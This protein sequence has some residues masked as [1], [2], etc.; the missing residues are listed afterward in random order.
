MPTR[1]TV[2]VL[3]ADVAGSTA[4]G[5]ALDPES[6]QR[7]MA[8]YFDAA[9]ACLERHGGSVEKF[10][11]DAVM[12][13]FGVPVTH[14]DD[15]LRAV[16]AAA[17]LREA[18]PALNDELERDFGISLELRI[19]VNTG[20]VV[21]GTEERLATGDAVNVAARLEQA[22]APCEILIGEA[23]LGLTRGAVEVEAVGPLTVKGKA[24]PLAAHRLLRVVEGAEPYERRLDSPL[25]GRSVELERVTTAFD[26]AVNDRRCT[27]V[28]VLG[29][30]GIGKSRLAREVATRLGSDALVLSG[31]CLPYGEG[32]SYWPL[33]EIFA[34]AGAEDEL[35]TALS[36]GSPEDVHWT[37]RK[38]LEARAREQPLG[39]VME[40]IHWAE[41]TLLDLIEHLADWTRD[42]PLCLLCLARPEL[43]DERPA[44]GSGRA[45]A[46]LFT[47]EPL[48]DDD[49]EQ[50]I[51]S[52]VG[53]SGLDPEVHARIRSVAEGNPLFVEQLVAAIAEGATEGVPSTIQALLSARLDTLSDD[54][55][56]VLERASV[57]GLEF[58]WEALAQLAPDRHRPSG[59]VL[60]ALVRKELIRPHEAIED[61]FRFRHMLIRDATYD[62]ITKER[63]SELHERFAD[64]L[65]GRG[66]EFDE[67]VGYHLEQAYRYLA[68]LGP[69]SEH[70]RGL[71]HRAGTVLGS[72]GRRAYDRG[73]AG[74]AANLFERTIALLP[75]DD[76]ARMRLLPAV[77]RTL[78]D[79]G[80]MDDA[81]AVLAEAVGLAETAG[82]RLVYAEATIVLAEHRLHTIT[83]GRAEALEDVESALQTFEDVGDKAGMAQAL[84]L[85]G[86]MVFWAGNA[87]A[88]TKDVEL[89]ARLADEVGDRAQEAESLHY[90]LA[91]MHRGPMPAGEVLARYDAMRP[92]TERNRRLEVTYLP[93]RAHLEAMQERFD[94]ARSLITQGIALVQELGLESLLHTHS[95][96]AA[97][98]VEL[99][100]G[101]AEAAERELLG[102]CEESERLGEL[103]FL[104]SNV[105][106]LVDAVLMQGRYEDAL[107]LTER[108]RPERLS[109]PEDADAHAGWRRVRA[110]ALARTGDLVEAERLGR[111]AVALL[112]A[113]DYL[114]AHATAVADLGEVLRLA[115][116]A[117]DAEATTAEA[118]QLYEQKG[119]VAAA[120]ALRRRAPAVSV[121]GSAAVPGEADGRDS[122]D[123]RP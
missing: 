99:L 14:E 78:R 31:R 85:R 71:A 24:Q 114:D 18:L 48:G 15:A 6:L 112:S 102:S 56:A 64:W 73:D 35:E 44:W 105:P 86:K 67:I 42:A 117:E 122:S 110:R 28:T 77:G 29:P 39:L 5:E 98:Y 50:L 34:S 43:L 46:E 74:A 79:A 63:R 23:T 113:T 90:V 91:A 51:D 49:A 61:S 40:D 4:L 58:E 22:A 36:A 59:G 95:R 45:N 37:I 88:A 57:V 33:R 116:K 81:E 65:D 11:G 12:A 118:I 41:P 7:V 111:E 97:G 119:N 54:E 93:T 87:A 55:R 92:R 115:G 60:S 76:P 47:L 72:S 84:A 32:I 1:K 20:D 94:V 26:R 66:D 9:R 82:D 62:R 107:Q 123:R 104:S 108:W 121:P 8:R 75:A 19:G 2:T 3:F 53:G 10:I 89:S 83:L 21:V 101:D 100:A 25:V 16:R 52:L 27:L 17:E 70:A 13:V 80:R 106:L 109:V 103:G 68:D 69:V 120:R 30:P 38:S 96:P